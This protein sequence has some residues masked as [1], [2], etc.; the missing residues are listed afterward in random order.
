MK[1]N[2]GLEV[3]IEV[4]YEYK[5]VIIEKLDDNIVSIR[6]SAD[7]LCP[8]YISDVFLLANKHVDMV[9]KIVAGQKKRFDKVADKILIHPAIHQ[10]FV[11]HWIVMCNAE[12]NAAQYTRSRRCYERFL[13]QLYQATKV[14]K[15][16]SVSKAPLLGKLWRVSL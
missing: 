13:G 2:E 7:D 11:K 14:A 1:T 12:D 4:Y 3:G 5:K 8:V 16:L 10:L 9:T 15:S 6:K